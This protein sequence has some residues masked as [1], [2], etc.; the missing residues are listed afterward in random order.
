MVRRTRLWAAFLVFALWLVAG[1]VP[2]ASDA[3]TVTWILLGGKGKAAKVSGLQLNAEASLDHSVLYRLNGLV[4]ANGL[5]VSDEDCLEEHFHGRVGDLQDRGTGC[6]LGTVA[7]Y[8][9]V[10][11][12]IQYASDALMSN[13]AATSYLSNVR[14]R[15]ANTAAEL[16]LSQLATLKQA[17]QSADP[18]QFPTRGLALASVNLAIQS[19]ADAAGILARLADQT[20]NRFAIR[21]AEQA[22]KR[23]AKSTRR[24]FVVLAGSP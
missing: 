24:A 21:R 10:P 12:P 5:I 1:A 13:L 3:G 17:L 2:A 20:S 14:F 8:A 11:A 18:Q 23:G 22:L 19:Q 7:R 15:D 4:W 9:E 6:G 16:S